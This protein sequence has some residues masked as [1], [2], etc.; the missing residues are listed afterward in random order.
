M[1]A[2]VRFFTNTFGIKRVE[3]LKY[4]FGWMQKTNLPHAPPALKVRS[5]KKTDKCSLG[6]YRAFFMLQAPV[7]M[8][9]KMSWRCESHPS[10]LLKKTQKT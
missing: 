2:N 1:F 10:L 4:Y 9:E 3:I 6:D 5:E 7:S 8:V